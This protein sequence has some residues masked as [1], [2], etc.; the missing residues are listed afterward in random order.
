MP[1]GI[2]KKGTMWELYNKLTGEIKGVF[3]TKK[4]AE[5]RRKELGYF[6]HKK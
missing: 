2:R 5:K 4:K 6:T 3:K 1:W